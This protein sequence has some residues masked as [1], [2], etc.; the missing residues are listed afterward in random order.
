MEHSKISGGDRRLKPSTLIR[1]SSWTTRRTRSFSKRIGLSP[2]QDDSTWY[3]TEAKKN[4]WSVTGDFI[5]RHH[6]EP[7]VKLYMPKEEIISPSDEYI[8][9]RNQNNTQVTSCTVGK[10]YWWLLERG[11]RKRIIECMEWTDF[12]GPRWEWRGNKQ[13]QDQT[14][15]GQMIRTM[16]LMQ[17]KAKQSKHGLLINRSSIMPEDCVVSS[18][19]N[20]MKKNLDTP[21]KNARRKLEIP[22]PAAML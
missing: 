12:H 15:C 6:V 9:R 11:W 18:S 1:E 4:Y 8:H 19:L 20:Q 2:L 7:R 10:T 13:P 14:M 22:M 16:S 17:R 3:D 5:Y 21:W